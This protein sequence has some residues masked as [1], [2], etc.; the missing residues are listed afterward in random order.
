MCYFYRGFI[1]GGLE[2]A[3]QLHY[4]LDRKGQLDGLIDTK[5]ALPLI[6]SD[7]LTDSISNGLSYFKEN[8]L[9]NDASSSWIEEGLFICEDALMKSSID[10]YFSKNKNLKTDADAR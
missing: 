4:L 10:S 1:K 2:T 6:F 9:I 3:R 7:Q 8:M 5:K